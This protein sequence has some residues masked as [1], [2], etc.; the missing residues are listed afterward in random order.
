MVSALVSPVA[1]K[2]TNVADGRM[3]KAE[4]AYLLEQLKSTE[5]EFLA[6]I[7]GLTP[8]QW[9]FKPAPDAWSIQECAEHII[10]A[11]DLIFNEAQKTLQSPAVPRLANATAEGDREVVA[12]VQDR[13]KKAKAPQV[14]QPTGKFPTPESA[15]KEFKARRMK[16]IAYAKS[17]QDPVR[18]HAGDAP[19]GGTCDVY[20][21]LLQM[22][23]HSARHTAQI[24]SVKAAP[25]YPQL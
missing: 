22:A 18:I 17:T 6:S 9:T 5:S 16:S 4:R 1:A 15:A 7:K 10:L 13:S 12:M 11:E 14:L 19:A 21:F 8:A 2:R 25:G 20:Q 3:S 23:S 24:N